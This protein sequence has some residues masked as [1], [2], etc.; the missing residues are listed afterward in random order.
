MEPTTKQSTS[1]KGT[2]HVSKGRKHRMAKSARISEHDISPILE[3]PKKFTPK[4]KW[5]AT[6]IDKVKLQALLAMH[7]LLLSAETMCLMNRA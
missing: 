4:A 7:G 3:N 2:N 5:S 6:D 1:V